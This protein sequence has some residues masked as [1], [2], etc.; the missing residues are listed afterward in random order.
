MGINVTRNV[1]LSTVNIFNVSM[2]GV[3]YYYKIKDLNIYPNVSIKK[4]NHIIVTSTVNTLRFKSV[5]DGYLSV[6]L[7]VSMLLITY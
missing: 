4:L 7:N 1:L 6:S 2:D 5:N 3:T